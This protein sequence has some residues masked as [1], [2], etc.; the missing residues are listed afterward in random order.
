MITELLLPY[1]PSVN[2]LFATNRVTSR[3]F[4]T[5]APDCSLPCDDVQLARITGLDHRRPNRLD[6][7]PLS[8]E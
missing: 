4:K 7:Q 1:P 6:T 5:P 2:N 3:R 8:V